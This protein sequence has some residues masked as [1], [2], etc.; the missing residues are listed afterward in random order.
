MINAILRFSAIFIIT[1]KRMFSQRGLVLATSLGII[2]A[3]ALSMSIP[4]YSDAVYQDILDN[5]VVPGNGGAIA[6]YSHPVFAYMYRYVGEWS[7]PV[8]REKLPPVNAYLSGPVAN[9]LGLAPMLFVKYQKTS[10]LKLFPAQQ[11]AYDSTKTPL[12]YVYFSV[13]SD[14]EKHITLVEGSMPG[15]A[16]TEPDSVINVLVSEDQ[17]VKLGLHQGELFNVYTTFRNQQT[18]TSSTFPVRVAGIWKANDPAELFWFY[19]TKE[20][21]EALLIPEKSL[22]DRVLPYMQDEINHV[23]WYWILDGSKIQSSQVPELLGRIASTRRKALNLLPYIRLDLSPEKVLQN[24][25]QAAQ[26]LTIYLYA[27][28]IPL[29]L[30]ILT[31]IGLVVD[32]VIE[33]RRNEIAVLR[34]RGSTQLQVLGM[35]VLE[36][37]LLGTVGLLV[38]TP[39]ALIVVQFFGKTKS[40]LDFTAGTSLNAQVTQSAVRFGFLTAAVVLAAQVLPT[41]IA[42]KRTIISYKQERAR[43][44][45]LPWWQRTWLDILLLIPAGYG[46]YLLRQGPGS[47]VPG[48]RTALS[49][50]P[51]QNPLL[52]LVPSLVIFA[53][54]LL[55]LRLL[56]LLMSAVAWSASYTHSVGVLMAARF[57]SRTSNSYS[58]PLILLVMTLSLST[59]TATLAQ[60]LDHH[61]HDQTFYKVGADMDVMEG[62]EYTGTSKPAGMGG[63]AGSN[64]VDA[65][66]ST[67]N[68][69]AEPARW[70]FLPVSEHL[71]IPG[72]MAAS[73]IGVADLKLKTSSGYD[74]ATF[75]G[76]DRVDFPQVAF[77]RRDFSPDSLG[78]LMNK[79]ALADEGVLVSRSLLSSNNLRIGDKLQ[80]STYQFDENVELNFRIVGVFDYFP[81]WYPQ[82]GQLV[83]GNLDP[84]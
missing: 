19:N 22:Y 30:M 49:N 2:A 51:F 66:N 33:R 21:N 39:A 38:G 5:A 44:I 12:A 65:V 32:M 9:D 69:A 57:L 29:L 84:F 68:N 74:T 50:D 3:I 63:T 53:F 1:S 64:S 52:L 46:V 62:G 60:T 7:N 15:S 47:I 58:A 13:L 56:P 34:S 24:Y 4:I 37:F 14:L 78:A 6:Q 75:I 80:V 23:V 20:F 54:T 16:S 81:T 10:V 73:R 36:S 82:E 41:L 59:F 35:G 40:F 8:K 79:L 42:A 61:M 55:L 77:W 70:I 67:T 71:K 48:V 45:Q 31:F 72:V 27:F 17:A 28:S 11:G 25:Q 43:Q 26:S 76:I 83:V 18:T